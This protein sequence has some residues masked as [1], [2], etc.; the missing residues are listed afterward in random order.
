MARA[1][2]CG[3]TLLALTDHDDTSGLEEA[4]AAAASQGVELVKGVEISVTWR[5]HTIHVVGLCIDPSC[6]EL[7]E[8]LRA[9]RSGRSRR[10]A[11][12]AA[13]LEKLGVRD[14]LEGARRHARNP[15][16]LGRAHFARYLVQRGNAA[17]V[18]SVFRK[19]LA[20]GK[21][22]YVAHQWT[23]LA[24]AVRWIRAS[25]GMAV[26]AH[27]GRYPLDKATQEA[28]LG[29]FRDAGGAGLE[30][31]SGS[32]TTEQFGLY[33][34]Y[35]SRFGLLASSGSDFHGPREGRWDLGA[36]PAL[37]PGCTPIWEKF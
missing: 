22:G 30:V 24:L 29:E 9:L 1:A 2:G 5:G 7:A 4:G 20:P 18:Q 32:H 3:V 10:A 8:G 12:M 15:E 21:P 16:L 6:G 27:P 28:L 26:L 17:D 35:A 37:P 14:A 11:Q 36:L 25:G 23:T 33:A 13:E 31:V 19:Y 34:R